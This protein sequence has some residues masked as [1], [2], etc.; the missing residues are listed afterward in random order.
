MDKEVFT[1]T[2]RDL[3]ELAEDPDEYRQAVS[4]IVVSHALNE[5]AG[6]EVFD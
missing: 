1:G 5:I 6:A 3:K 4:K 2:V